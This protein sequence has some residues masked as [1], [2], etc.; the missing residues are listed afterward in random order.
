MT[1]DNSVGILLTHGSARVLLACDAEK[2]SKEYRANGRYT[3][4]LADTQGR[5]Y[6][7]TRAALQR[8]GKGP[9]Y[10]RY[11]LR[12]DSGELV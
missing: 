10:S 5:G 2:N 11:S 12:V 9:R 4:P 6:K 7:K 8:L 1:N 3:G